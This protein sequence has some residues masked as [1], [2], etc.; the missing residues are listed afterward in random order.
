MGGG[1]RAAPA[2][3]FSRRGHGGAT[4]MRLGRTAAAGA[5]A[6]CLLALAVGVAPRA[7]APA[8]PAA[9]ARVPIRGKPGTLTGRV[10]LK[11]EKPDLSAR[12]EA[13]RKA[14]KEKDEDHCLKTA[15]LDQTVEQS[16]RVG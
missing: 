13:L 4:L 2:L 8:A 7:P 10:T 5:A 9:A 3:S 11:G 6:V 16:V 15:P 12:T 14:M 1:R